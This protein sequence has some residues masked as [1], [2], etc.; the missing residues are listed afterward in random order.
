M[1]PPA[2]IP[3]DSTEGPG[4][5]GGMARTIVGLGFQFQRGSKESSLDSP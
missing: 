4:G 2:A 5:Y 3:C 1:P